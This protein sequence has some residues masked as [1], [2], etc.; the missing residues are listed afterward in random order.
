MHQALCKDALYAI[1]HL[2]FIVTMFTLQ[3]RKQVW[4]VSN[5][6]SLGNEMKRSETIVTPMGCRA[7]RSQ[8]VLGLRTAR[9]TTG[10]RRQW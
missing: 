6:F 9:E 2:L 10:P 5:R 7:E 8:A 4:Q 3:M 1:S